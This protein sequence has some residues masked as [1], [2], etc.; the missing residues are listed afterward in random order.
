MGEAMKALEKIKN[1]KKK[2]TFPNEGICRVPNC[3]VP[4]TREKGGR[5]G[6]CKT[7]YYHA[8]RFINKG[9][10]SWEE[11]DEAWTE[12]KSAPY[13]GP[14][15]PIDQ[16]QKTVSEIHIDQ[17]RLS[18]TEFSNE[19][20]RFMHELGHGIWQLDPQRLKSIPDLLIVT[21]GGRVLFRELKATGGGLSENQEAQIQRMREQGADVDVWEP[22]DLE[23][24]RIAQDV[25]EGED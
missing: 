9:E 12:V 25:S 18:E 17:I 4:Y 1:T 13:T 3:G 16:I 5:K 14:G 8:N 24:G 2:I 19:I 15:S 20:M 23:S 22:I 6:M 21:K 10:T 11:I 7:H